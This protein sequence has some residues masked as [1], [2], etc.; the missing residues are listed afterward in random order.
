M[1]TVSFT[2][3]LARFLLAPFAMVEAATVGDALGAVFA[4]RS[5]LRGYVLDDQGALRRHV[6]VYINGR[7][8]ND[9][10]RLTDP[11]GPRDEIYVFQALSGG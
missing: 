7:P 1:P 2:R 9:R 11:V 10:A 3:A 4:S 5:T 8:V 6:V